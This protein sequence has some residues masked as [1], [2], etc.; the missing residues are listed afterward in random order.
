MPTPSKV[1]MPLPGLKPVRKARDLS[2][3][4]LAALSGTT[5]VNISRI[6]N[7]QPATMKTARAL[8]KALR[9]PVTELVGY[10][11]SEGT[12]LDL[13]GFVRS[14]GY[15]PEPFFTDLDIPS[16]RVAELYEAS[17]VRLLHAEK[18]ARAGKWTDPQVDLGV[19]LELAREVREFTT[20]PWA[21]E[22]HERVKKLASRAA[23]VYGEEA[24]VSSSKEREMR[25]AEL[26]LTGAA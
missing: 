4:Q 17:Y 19:L 15:E 3:P 6:E 2:Q 22:V 18:R 10:G 9:V 8:A 11:R 5:Q 24:K 26:E 12:L 13:P 7:G 14:F 25:N 21:R 20:E 16:K 1:A 23:T